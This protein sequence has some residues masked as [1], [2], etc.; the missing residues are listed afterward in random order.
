MI[1]FKCDWQKSQLIGPQKTIHL[2]RNCL[3]ILDLLRQSYE[4]QTDIMYAELFELTEI[5][6]E[7][8]LSEDIK[9]INAGLRASGSK[10]VAY[11]K[12]NRILLGKKPDTSNQISPPGR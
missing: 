5:T 2:T 7:E 1:D 6:E 4:F 11:F 9:I 10:F 3:T 12:K 8:E